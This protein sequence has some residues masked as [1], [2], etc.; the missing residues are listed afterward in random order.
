[1]SALCTITCM[2]AFRKRTEKRRKTESGRK[3]SLICFWYTEQTQ[4]GETK[5]FPGGWLQQYCGS[6]VKHRVVC[7]PSVLGCVFIGTS[8]CLHFCLWYENSFR[9][10]VYYTAPLPFSTS[11]IKCRTGPIVQIYNDPA[12]SWFYHHIWSATQSINQSIQINTYILID[13]CLYV[14]LYNHLFF[15]LYNHILISNFLSDTFNFFIIWILNMNCVCVIVKHLHILAIFL[16]QLM[17]RQ[18]NEPTFYKLVFSM[19]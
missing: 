16:G 13:R 10:M 15:S 9:C 1:M 12:N 11:N 17:S 2:H 3:N 14:A 18:S 8:P 5:P 4:W 19:F 7:A 6:E